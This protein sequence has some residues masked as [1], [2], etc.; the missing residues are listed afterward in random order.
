MKKVLKLAVT[1]LFLLIFAA[2]CA[3]TKSKSEKAAARDSLQAMTEGTLARLYQN[4]PAAKAVEAD[5][6][7]YAV[8][9]D[10]GFKVLFMGGAQGNPE[11]YQSNDSSA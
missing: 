11:W 6:V 2:G 10:F 5:A 3:G 8:F 7:G 4:E 9:I 1:V